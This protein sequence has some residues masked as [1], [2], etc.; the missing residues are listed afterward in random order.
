M[1]VILRLSMIDMWYPRICLGRPAPKTHATVKV[2]PADRREE[3]ARGQGFDVAGCTCSRGK[4][5]WPGWY[6]QSQLSVGQ[7]TW[8]A[9]MWADAGR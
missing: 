1:S 8:K 4:K 9:A 6:P 2:K 3:L 5:G 7:E